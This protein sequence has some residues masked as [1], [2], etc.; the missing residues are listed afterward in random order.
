[1]TERDRG[2]PGLTLPIRLAIAAGPPLLS[3]GSHPIQ[4]FR[5][6]FVGLSCELHKTVLYGSLAILIGL[7]AL[8]SRFSSLYVNFIRL[9]L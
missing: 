3:S 8:S 7:L 1:M 2:R 9:G 5:G 6:R 4:S